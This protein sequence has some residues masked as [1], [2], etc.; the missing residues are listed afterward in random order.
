MNLTH[1]HRSIRAALHTARPLKYA[2]LSGQVLA[3]LIAGRVIRVSTFLERLGQDA[4][5]TARYG[6]PFGRHAAKHYRAARRCEPLRCW[7]EN[8]ADRWI[9][10]FVYAPTDPALAAAVG[11]YKR[12]AHLTTAA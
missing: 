2:A 12:T 6:S 11:S 1:I 4:E 9:H 8:A 10:V 5:F 3:D 7:I